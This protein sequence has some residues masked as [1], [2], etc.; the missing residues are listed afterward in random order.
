[1]EN[2]NSYLSQIE[3]VYFLGIGGIGMSAIAR[4]FRHQGKYVMGYDK[5][6][7]ALTI[8]LEI[9]G[10][11]LNY[12]DSALEVPELIHRTPREKILIIYTPA[13]PK[14]SVLLHWFY[15]RDFRIEKRSAVLGLIT[16]GSR[17]IAVAGTHG[18]TTTSTMIAH[19]LQHSGKGC[20]AFLGGIST[21]YASNLLLGPSDS[22]T[23]VEADEYDRSFLTLSPTLSVITSMDADHLD[24]YG[25]TEAMHE[26]YQAF[27]DRLHESGKLLFREGLP[28]KLD[29]GYEM[30]AYGIGCDSEHSGRIRVPGDGSF[31]LDYKCGDILWESIELGLP[32]TH[33]AENALAAIAVAREVGLTE[34]EIRDALT[35][36]KGVRRRFEFRIKRPGLVMIDDYAHHPEEIRSFLASVRMIYPDKRIT[37]VFQPHL[38]SRTRDFLN[39]FAQVLSSLDEI[40]LL[41]VYPA[42]ELPIP[43][44]D[45]Q[46]LLDKITNSSKKLVDKHGLLALL[47]SMNPELLVM[48]GA[49]DIDALVPQIE[50][51]L[52]NC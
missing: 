17:T 45:S 18:K 8:E 2:S 10:M 25:N 26:S 30:V 7:T 36:F 13:I 50:K 39:E 48:M 31:L 20:N 47:Q 37:G 3:V 41:E 28:L 16:A 52:A 27:A 49:G 15:S 51:G 32:G 29:R 22:W 40:I 1:M 21:N 46:L 42:R 24:I 33:N 4:Y 11:E 6:R 43:G 23:V 35:S 19:M 9:E 38:F 34:H 12:Q 14:D 44:I 5:T